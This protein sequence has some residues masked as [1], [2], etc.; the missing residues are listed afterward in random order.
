MLRLALLSA[1]LLALLPIGCGG[2]GGG[3]PVGTTV[4]SG[5]RPIELSLMTADAQWIDVAELRGQPTLIFL[6]TTWDP[7]SQAALSPVSRFARRHPEAHV[8]GLA[9]QPDARLLVDAYVHALDPSIAV[10]YDPRDQ[11]PLGT[12]TL[13]PIQS[14]PAVIVLDAEGYEVRRYHGFP[15]RRVLERLLYEAGGGRADP[16][17]AAEGIT[18][19]PTPLPLMGREVDR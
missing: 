3:G 6:F 12:S 9:A 8:F 17:E 10:S 14:V 13:G 1:A 2:G 7:A 19:E 15:S 4:A 16:D 11:V 5:P 18:V